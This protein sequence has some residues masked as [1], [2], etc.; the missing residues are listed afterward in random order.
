ML[1]LEKVSYNMKYIKFFLVLGLIA[2]LTYAGDEERSNF[3]SALLHIKFGSVN[4]HLR[5]LDNAISCIKSNAIFNLESQYDP[6]KLCEQVA[7]MLFFAN[8][9]I[10]VGYSKWGG[11]EVS[12]QAGQGYGFRGYNGSAEDDD[13]AVI[14]ARLA[15]FLGQHYREMFTKKGASAQ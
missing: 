1:Y 13:M 3:R 11:L 6:N 5:Q 8:P 15:G 7:G 10:Y 14:Q 12:D 4:E 9:K 2:H